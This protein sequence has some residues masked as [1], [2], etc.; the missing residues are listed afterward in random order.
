MVGIWGPVALAAGTIA[1]GSAS[2]WG[3]RVLRR[4][5]RSGTAVRRGMVGGYGAL[6]LLS[7]LCGGSRTDY[8]EYCLAALAAALVATM[9][10]LGSA[11][12]TPTDAPHRRRVVLA[13]GAHPDDLELACGG[14]LAR[15]VDIGHEV[16]GVI[17]TSGSQGGDASRRPDEARR[18]ARFMG[19]QSLAVHDF[20]DANLPL[21]QRELTRVIEEAIA[22]YGPDVI[23]THSAHDQHQ[24]HLAV[25][26]ATLRAAR[27]S[28]SILCFESPSVTRDFNPSVYFDI[29][30]YVDVKVSAV[31]S[32]RDQ[33]GK[34]YLDRDALQGTATFRGAQVRR[35]HAEGFEVVRL[36]ADEA[37]VF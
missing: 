37:G 30:D 1:L 31:A 32:H 2:P 24:D 4:R 28:H 35:R 27:S 36:L 20:P 17:M 23:L 15:F 3:S 25:H 5:F 6:A 8:G 18:G 9:A 11:A 7:V 29:H 13:I 14:T 19:L 26:E 12:I 21:V 33:A 34:R 10:V 16:H 22:A